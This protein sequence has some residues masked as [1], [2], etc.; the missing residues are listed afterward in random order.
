MYWELSTGYKL[1]VTKI[2]KNKKFSLLLSKEPYGNEF[3]KIG[4]IDDK[5]SIT[6]L[7]EAFFTESE[8]NQ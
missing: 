3:T 2:G 1:W 4:M 5:F 7:Q 6:R 8:V